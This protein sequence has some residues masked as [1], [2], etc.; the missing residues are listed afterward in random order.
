MP[1]PNPKPGSHP[2][3]KSV[4]L[5]SR[6]TTYYYYYCYQEIIIIEK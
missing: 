4:A 1:L 3:S 2:V 6:S 5:K